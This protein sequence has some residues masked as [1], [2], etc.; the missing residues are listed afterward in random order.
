MSV[1]ALDDPVGQAL[2]SNHAH[3]AR[4]RGRTLTY[5]G[6]VATFSAVP[7]DPTQQ[8][9]DDLATLLGPGRFADLFSSPATPPATWEPVFRLDGLQLVAD[10]AA[11]P[12]P[13]GDPLPGPGLVEL[14]PADVPAMLA[15]AER[16]R[17]GPFWQRTH[18]MGRYVGIRDGDRLVAMAGER[19]RPPG[20]AEISAVCT[21]PEARGRGLAA[22]LVA[23]VAREIHARGEQ[24][25]LH[26]IATNTTAVRLYQRLGFLVRREVV[27]HGYRTPLR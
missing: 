10:P 17:P 12:A 26:V 7:L 24:A 4:G 21:A 14:G 18:E 25:F 9:W 23:D 19:L 27:F 16:T 15:L 3:L 1:A 6:A 11:L 5:D 22:A 13:P 8:D 20:S 2:R